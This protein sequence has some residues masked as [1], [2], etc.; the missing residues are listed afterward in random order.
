MVLAKRGLDS[1]SEA[2][3]AYNAVS[4]Q[5]LQELEPRIGVGT[6]SDTPKVA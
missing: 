3:S 5:L 2:D 6:E 4:S 1:W